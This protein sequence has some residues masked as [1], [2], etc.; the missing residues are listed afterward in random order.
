MAYESLSVSAASSEEKS[1][2]LSPLEGSQSLNI[3]ISWFVVT[4]F[5]QHEKIHGFDIGKSESGF[6]IPS[7]LIEFC[8]KRE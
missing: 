5:I 8:L 3:E 2:T 6:D 1:I 4:L 7:K